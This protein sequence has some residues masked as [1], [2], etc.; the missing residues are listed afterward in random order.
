MKLA[1]RVTLLAAAAQVAVCQN[2][3]FSTVV[4]GT[5]KP[6]I[7]IPG[8]E[9]PGTV[10]DDTVRHFR[11]RYQVHVLTLAGFA[12]QPAIPGLRLRAVRD[13]LIRYIR[14]RRLDRP[15]LVGHSLGGF[16]A[17]WVAA[18][19]PE[20]ASRV[21]SLDGVPFL[22]ALF[23]PAAQP[24]DSKE[25][26]ERMQKLYA[27]LAPPQLEAMSKM[28]LTQ[29]I[30]DAK[31]VEMAAAWASQSDSAFVGQTIYDLMTTDLRPEMP[32]VTAPLLLIG[33]G[34][35]VSP[36]VRAAYEDQVAKA[37]DH[38]VVFADGALH[39]I[40]L[41]DPSFLFG[42]MDRFLADGGRHA[43]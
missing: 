11:D 12:G 31:N 37:P 35:G 16:L 5:G 6:M 14:D 17:L 4:S 25:E 8:L 30:S 28:A 29:M 27:S 3:S 23:N 41:D 39:F 10:W 32:R 18:S 22:P 43:R 42:A 19:A 15:V 26:A 20:L 13:D 7:L 2:M 33:A 1:L 40:M 38:R 36:Q 9:C 21:V 24:G 34:K